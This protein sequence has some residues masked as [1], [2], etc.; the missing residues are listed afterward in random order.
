[1]FWNILA[2]GLYWLFQG[3]AYVFFIFNPEWRFSLGTGLVIK[4]LKRKTNRYI[5]RYSKWI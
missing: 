5:N 3:L 2:S 1:M 4:N